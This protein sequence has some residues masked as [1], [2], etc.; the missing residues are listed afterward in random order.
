PYDTPIVGYG[1]NTV[2]TLRL[3]SAK[4]AEEFDFQDFNQGDYVAAVE[5]KIGAETLT[6]VLYPNDCIYLGK[7]LRFKQQ[8]FFVACALWDIFRRFKADK[9]PWS[10][11]PNRVAI[12]MN[13]TH[14][15]LCVPEMMRLLV[16]GEGVDWDAAWEIT[17]K[18]LAYT[19]HTLLPEALETWPVP[20]F[21]SLLPRHLQIIYEINHRFLQKVAVRFP[22][23]MEKIARMSLIGEGDV[24]HVRM[25]NLCVLGSHSTNGVSALHTDL[26]RRRV[27]PDF[28]EMFPERFNNKTNGITPR[29]WLLKANPPL[30]ALITE[31][32]GDRWITELDELRKLTPLAEDAAFRSRFR[33]VKRQAKVA[34]A[35]YLKKTCNMEIDPDTIFDVQVKRLHEYKRQL[36]NALHIVIIYLRLKKNP[37]LDIMPRTFIFGAKAAPGYQMAKLII[38]LINNI[39][40][41]INHD[42]DV[43]RKLRVYFVPN[44]RVSLAE[45]IIPAADVSE[46]I[47]TAGTEASGTGNM[48]FMLN[49]ALTL[50]TLDGANIEILEEVGKDN[51]FIFGLTAAQVAELRPR[52]NPVEIYRTNAEIREACDILFKSNLF[53]ISEPNIFAPIYSALFEQGDH[54]MHLADLPAYAEAQASIDRLYRDQEAWSRKA[55]LNVAAAG[56]FSSDRTI[57]EYAREI[58]NIEPCPVNLRERRGETIIEMRRTSS[59]DAAS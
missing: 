38:K 50:G 23:N 45:R 22:G 56:K 8:Y 11:L 17:Q 1:G 51:I 42:S 20:M 34:L 36:L 59:P 19:N 39:A 41:V 31:A 30:A 18:C 54:Y 21:E 52:Y 5:N 58:W 32:I 48:K 9:Q 13:D 28:A 27:L 15:A 2:N 12:Q 6:K 24:K 7:E 3:F 4:A 46:Q 35:D 44:Y 37:R 26:L 40:G 49:G 43:N 29:R 16:D 57:R 33:A 47:S 55:I 25:A 10:E 14:P 53:S